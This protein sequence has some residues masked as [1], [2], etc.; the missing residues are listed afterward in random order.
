M[1]SSRRSV[2]TG[3][4]RTR[5]RAATARAP[6]RLCVHI[7]SGR[8]A[9]TGMRTA[10]VASGSG[11]GGSARRSGWARSDRSLMSGLAGQVAIVTGASRGIGRAISDA[12][13]AEGC[14]VVRCS[15][16]G[17]AGERVDVSNPEE[18]RRFISRVLAELGRVDVLV[19]NAA[20]NY[21]GSVLEMPPDQFDELFAT[22]VRGVF[23]AIQAV[24]PSMV[25]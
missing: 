6:S 17:A 16:S 9:P 1:R 22:N 20:V 14:D 15:R 19:N 23:Y 4:W 21:S 5:S 7:S 13:A 25:E 11:S 10:A 3:A 2:S 24:A 18:L 8:P 12:L